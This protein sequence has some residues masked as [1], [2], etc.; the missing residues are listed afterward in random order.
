MFNWISILLFIFV[1]IPFFPPEWFNYSPKFY[2][3]DP[4]EPGTYQKSQRI[5]ILHALI[6]LVIKSLSVF[7][8][9]I[10]LPFQVIMHY[11][12]AIILIVFLVVGFDIFYRHQISR[13]AITLVSIGIFALYLERLIEQGKKINGFFN[14]F[15]WEAKDDPDNVQAHNSSIDSIT[16]TDHKPS[17]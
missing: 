17:L 3:N 10:T 4:L 6:K 9:D 8:Y 11:K 13:E 16:N 15:N 5:S 7:V 12:E 14:L 1:I 2:I